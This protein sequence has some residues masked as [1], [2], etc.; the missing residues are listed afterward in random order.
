MGEFMINGVIMRGSIRRD[1]IRVRDLLLGINF[2]S[3][4]NRF[5]KRFGRI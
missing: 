3:L 1:G 2:G 4:Y 5:A